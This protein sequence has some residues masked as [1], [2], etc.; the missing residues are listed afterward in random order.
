MR[1]SN[2]IS[3]F[4]VCGTLTKTNNTYSYI[5][6]VVRSNPVKLFL[7][8]ILM[9]LLDIISV[10]GFSELYV[11]NRLVKLLA[12]YDRN[13]LKNKAFR[14]CNTLFNKGLVNID[15]VSIIK[16][17]Y[18]SCYLLSGSIDLPVIEIGRRLR[19][20]NIIATSL[21]YSGEVCTGRIKMD[22]LGE[23]LDYLK[24]LKNRYNKKE[25]KIAFFSDNKEDEVGKS[26]VDRYIKVIHDKKDEKTNRNVYY[27]NIY[28]SDDSITSNNLKS[29][30]LLYIPT[31]YTFLS[32]PLSIMSLLLKD[33]FITY[34]ILFH[35]STFRMMSPILLYTVFL[36]VYEIGYLFNDY[37]AVRR[38]VNPTR[39]LDDSFRINLPFFI[40]LRLILL[41]IAFK[42]AQIEL[43]LL[44]YLLFTLFVI[45]AHSLIVV[46]RNRLY[47]FSLLVLLKIMY[48][49]IFIFKLDG[50][51]NL[52][53]LYF[54][55]QLYRAML[56]L[57]K[58]FEFEKKYLLF[59]YYFIAVGILC[60]AT[61]ITGS[62]I[63]TTLLIYLLILNYVLLLRHRLLL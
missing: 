38:E 43:F 3:V 27:F 28:R 55:S 24:T 12:G 31:L 61:F 58:V 41:F 1:K 50:L 54:S 56:Y 45:L 11:R 4:D 10:F 53:I 6:Y 19:V 37:I 44:G 47:S 26:V 39:R 16:K 23:K 42:Y 33:I 7:F 5:Y 9:M 48:P 8:I 20:K 46:K 29:N 14:Y 13:Y 32:R 40:I 36:T 21:Q 15:F 17:N 2:Y 59:K 18:R 62:Y 51:I 25:L 30:Y 60:I 35:N 22:I 34:V 52:F 63:H 57:A 49:I